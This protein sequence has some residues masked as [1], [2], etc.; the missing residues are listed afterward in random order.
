[1]SI[2]S[3]KEKKADKSQK[4][5]SIIS[6][7]EKKA[8]KNQK[9]K[10]VISKTEKKANKKKSIICKKEVGYKQKEDGRQNST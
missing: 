2:V 7:K 3:N 1:M 4:K 10:S 6:K 9:K 5:K 8:D